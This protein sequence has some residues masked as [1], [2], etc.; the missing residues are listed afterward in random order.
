MDYETSCDA[1]KFES[2]GVPQLYSLH[3]GVK[4]AINERPAGDGVVQL[5]F[6]VPVEGLYTLSA[7]RLDTQAWIKDNE[8]GAV[9]NLADGAYT[10]SADVGCDDSRFA[11]LL[12]SNTTGIVLVENDNIVAA[13]GGVNIA[14]GAVADIFDA[15]GAM[16][17]QSVS[18]FV[19]LPA[20][21]YVVKCADGNVKVVVK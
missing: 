7:E 21:T 16:V 5:G 9:H 2:A 8:T 12:Q 14:G 10:F 17:A 15:A 18:G 3:A 19:A 6:S 20:G 4:Y 13:D 11:L 1:A